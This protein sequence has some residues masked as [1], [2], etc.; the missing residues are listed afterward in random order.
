MAQKQLCSACTLGSATS[1][2]ERTAPK[3]LPAQGSSIAIASGR[4][5]VGV[6]AA[7]VRPEVCRALTDQLLD[8]P[9]QRR[10]RHR[11]VILLSTKSVVELCD[12]PEVGY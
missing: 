7:L 2:A 11:Q 10:V 1:H 5:T 12:M 3:R 9:L 4:G 8:T 6:A